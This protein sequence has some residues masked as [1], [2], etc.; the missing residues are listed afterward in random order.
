MLGGGGGAGVG[1][2]VE[3]KEGG[4]PG[5]PDVGWKEEVEA[6][7]AYLLIKVYNSMV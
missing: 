1:D 5:A 7:W 3:G 2:A 4:Q 6:L